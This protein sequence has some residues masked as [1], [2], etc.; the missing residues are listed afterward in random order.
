LDQHQHEQTSPN[1]DGPPATPAPAVAKTSVGPALVSALRAVVGDRGLVEGRTSLKTYE[2]DGYTLERSAPDLVVLPRTTDEAS[3]VITLLAEAGVPFVPR[4]AGTGVSGGCLAVG[5]S[6][7]IGTARMRAIR[8]IDWDNQVAEVEA[9]VVNLEVTRTVAPKGLYYA[10][11]PSSQSACTIGGNVAENSG[12]PHTLK[13]GV[14]VNHLL[15]LE[16]VLPDGRVVWLDREA[17]APGYDLVG[18]VTGSEGTLGL[19]T[20][21]RV[22][23]LRKPEAVATLLA[24]FP[25]IPEATRA[26]S[27]IIA[28][29]I[30]P[31]ALELMDAL[32][33]SAVEA[34]YGFGFPEGAGAVL[35]I[36][37]DGLAAGLGA[38]AS[39]VEACCR[40]EGASDVKRAAT[41][42]ERALLWK[43]RKR[44]FGAMGRLAPNYCTQDGV[45]PRSR[46]PEIAAV[47]AEVAARHRLRIALLM[48]AGDGNIHPLVLYDDAVPGEAARVI[49]AGNEILRACLDLGGSIT[50]EHGIGVEKLEL[51]AEAF[52]AD[53]L[54][55]MADVRGAFNPRGLCNPDKV[56]PSSRSCVEVTRPR[57]RGG[58]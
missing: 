22:K 50:G 39:R 44:V 25:G 49:A 18:L 1:D 41:E 20:A 12:G 43:S 21:A 16:L 27:A 30:I 42:E 40:A 8:S 14:T 36:E 24:V 28:A 17:D 6:V 56:E 15:A 57:P 55:A 3:R 29:G 37:L 48:H 26:V 35:L 5:A 19:V 4:G 52:T 23:L 11:D 2:C 10:P 13:Y 38:L 51:M 31:A 46:L 7:M 47:I 54:A 58:G 45:V 9:G 32:V 34:A 53:T 33:I